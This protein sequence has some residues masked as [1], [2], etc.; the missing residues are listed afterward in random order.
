[1]TPRANVMPRRYRSV[2]VASVPVPLDAAE[3]ER[4]FVGREAYRRTGFIVV[5]HGARTAVV[6]VERTA[7][8]DGEDPLFQRITSVELLAGPDECSYV[9]DPS[10]DTAVPTQMARAASSAP[11][12]R[13]VV[14]RGRYEHV[15]FI[16]DPSPLEIDVVE[17]VPPEPAKLVDQIRRVLE[18]AED[19]PPIAIRPRLVDLVADRPPGRWLFPCRGSGAAPAGSEISYLDE[20]PARRDWVLVGCARSREIHKWFYGD[21]PRSVESCPRVLAGDVDRPTIVKCCLHEAGVERDGL[22]VTVP[23]GASLDEIREGLRLLAEAA[24]EVRPNTGAA[25]GAEEQAWAPA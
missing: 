9:V 16:L 18:T 5:H 24:A 3:L 1:M 20:R 19:L 4:W 2:S 15:N 12:A 22:R 14:V 17:V 13:C 6:R 7:G 10:V 25:P 11:G 23:W 21:V 8:Q